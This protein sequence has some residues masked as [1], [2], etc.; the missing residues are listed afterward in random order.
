MK[1]YEETQVLA[2]HNVDV[3]IKLTN[4]TKRGERNDIDTFR[5]GVS[6]VRMY[7]W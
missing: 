3:V 7:R 6:E 2:N 4:F 1:G 5:G